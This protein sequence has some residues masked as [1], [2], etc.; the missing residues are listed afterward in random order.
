MSQDIGDVTTAV[1]SRIQ[2]WQ[3]AVERRNH[4]ATVMPS[5]PY[6]GNLAE[7]IPNNGRDR[8]LSPATLIGSFWYVPAPAGIRDIYRKQGAKLDAHQ[9]RGDFVNRV[10]SV[11][12]AVISDA[13]KLAREGVSAVTGIPGWAFPVLIIAIGAYAVHTV[14]GGIGDGIRRV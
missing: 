3:V 5:G 14:V 4:V 11:P 2:V 7:R 9:S 1:D 13:G 10:Q 6:R 12:G 8:Y